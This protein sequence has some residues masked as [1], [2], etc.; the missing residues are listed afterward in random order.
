MQEECQLPWARWGGSKESLGENGVFSAHRRAQTAALEGLTLGMSCSE[1]LSRPHLTV[2][3]VCLG[4]QRAEPNPFLLGWYSQPAKGTCST[5][6]LGCRGLTTKLTG[7]SDQL[8]HNAVTGPNSCLSVSPNPALPGPSV[9]APQVQ[10]EGV[11]NAGLWSLHMAGLGKV[12]AESP[13]STHAPC[14]PQCGSN[15]PTCLPLSPQAGA[16]PGLQG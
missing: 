7:V 12:G 4:L 13:S 14:S 10:G 1:L 15:I 11:T 9:L 2:P 16:S 3:R 6:L 5:L 8:P